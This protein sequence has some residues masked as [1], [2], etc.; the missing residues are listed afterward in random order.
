M[1]VDYDPSART[2]ATSS[3]LSLSSIH[4]SDLPSSVRGII[5][6]QIFCG[7]ETKGNPG[8]SPSLLSCCGGSLVDRRLPPSLLPPLVLRDSR[9]RP[10][11]S[12]CAPLGG[13]RKAEGGDQE[14]R[15]GPLGGGTTTKGGGASRPTLSPVT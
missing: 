4:M 12:V 14:G 7:G 8:R 13:M 1:C 11:S 15:G 10:G 3:S 6:E 2:Y 9:S 5:R